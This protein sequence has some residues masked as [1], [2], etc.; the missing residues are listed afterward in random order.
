MILNSGHHFYLFQLDTGRNY[1]I[2]LLHI[3]PTSLKE[4]TTDEIQNSGGLTPESLF[5]TTMLC[6]LT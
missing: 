4:S 3:S 6:C 5:L 2:E 1:I